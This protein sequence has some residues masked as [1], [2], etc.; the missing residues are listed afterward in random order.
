MSPTTA[1]ETIGHAV[2]LA[3]SGDSIIVAAATYT[4]NLKIGIPLN[5]VG[6]GAPTTIVDAGHAAT[7]VTISSA[8]ANVTLSKLTIRNGFS[9]N[10]GGVHS[11]G[12]LSLNSQPYQRERGC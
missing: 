9:G 12:T 4:E 2:S 11:L 6:S 1:C 5:I 8:S 7:V 10:G 3:K